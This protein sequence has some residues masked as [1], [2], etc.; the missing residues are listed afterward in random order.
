MSI[1]HLAPL[2]MLLGAVTYLLPL[3]YKKLTELGRLA[4]AVGLLALLLLGLG[5]GRALIEFS[6]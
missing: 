2:V 5:H 1:L 4:F 3:P 6:R